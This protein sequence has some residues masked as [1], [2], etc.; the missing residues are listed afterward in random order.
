MFVRA[1]LPRPPSSA[2]AMPEDLQEAVPGTSEAESAP[3]KSKLDR[4]T[5]ELDRKENERIQLL[6]EN[7]NLLSAYV[8]TAKVGGGHA[9]PE[10]TGLFQELVSASREA[11]EALNAQMEKLKGTIAKNEREMQQVGPSS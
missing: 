6:M 10:L 1:P 9:T 3:P 4:L 8:S 5:A 11:R 7:V 2:L